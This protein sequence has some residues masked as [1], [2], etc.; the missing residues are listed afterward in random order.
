[1]IPLIGFAGW[2]G[3]GKTSLLEALIPIMIQKGK[4]VAAIKHC[5]H[6]TDSGERGKDSERLVKAGAAE[7]II[8]GPEEP[9]LPCAV[10]MIQ[11]HA[12]ADMI[13]VEGFKDAEIPK[14]GLER[15]SIN[16]G[17]TDS[18]DCFCAV[19][20]DAIRKKSTIPCFNW[21][22]TEKIGEFILRHE[23]D[24][25]YDKG[26]SRIK[27]SLDEWLLEAKRAEKASDCGMY[28]FHDGVVRITP[29]AK[30]RSGEQTNKTVKAVQF[31]CD[32]EKTA[33]AVNRVMKMPGIFYAR[34]WLNEGTLS[35]GEDL[36]LVLVGGDIRPHVVDA[37]QSLVSEIKNSCVTEQEIF[38]E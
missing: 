32:A 30:V 14:I 38:G 29:K 21:D 19:V 35:V 28:L 15:Q 10:K 36:M 7:C 4:R 2:S 8:C 26:I 18:E 5:A 9:D 20:T 34:V 27:P 12:T 1:M 37:L 16:K 23:Q 11:N 6:G 22:E 13:F 24:F 31:S 25:Q 17:L 33:E 3:V